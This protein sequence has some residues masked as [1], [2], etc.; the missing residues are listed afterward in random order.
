MG[1][2]LASRRNLRRLVLRGRITRRGRASGK[3]SKNV[4]SEIF[5]RDKI[6][7]TLRLVCFAGMLRDS[8]PYD[9]C[10]L[11]PPRQPLPLPP[12]PL[13]VECHSQN[14]VAP[15]WTRGMWN[16][17]K[18]ARAGVVMHVKGVDNAAGYP[19]LSD[20]KIQT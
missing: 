17:G 19:F 18:V 14:T 1:R 20:V 4:H 7:H 13:P 9:H 5:E 3:E 2:M 10:H 12:L 15:H 8:I 16:I 11:V 6:L